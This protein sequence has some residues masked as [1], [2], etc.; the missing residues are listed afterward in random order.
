VFAVSFS[1]VLLVLLRRLC[2]FVSDTVPVVGEKRLILPTATNLVDV[3]LSK[4]FHAML[5]LFTIATAAATTPTR[6]DN[7]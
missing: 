6:S 7:T 1:L 3:Q 5:F 4:S 2:H